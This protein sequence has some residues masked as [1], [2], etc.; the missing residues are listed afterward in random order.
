MK[1][2]FLIIA[3]LATAFLQKSFAQEQTITPAEILHR[4]YDVK[5]AL[6]SGN[7]ALASEKAGAFVKAMNGMNAQSFSGD[8][9]KTFV[10]YQKKLTDHAQEIAKTKNIKDQREHFAGLSAEMYALAKAVKLTTQP[11]YYDFCTMKKTHWLSSEA[12]IKNPYFGSAMLTCGKIE[13]TL[14]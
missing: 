2:T 5:N 10:S 14:K 13:E 11:I 7:A 1:K 3:F 12:T 4:Y 8:D 9:G 6:V